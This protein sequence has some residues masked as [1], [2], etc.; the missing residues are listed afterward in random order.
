MAALREE[1]RSG[2]SLSAIIRDNPCL[3]L[4]FMQLQTAPIRAEP[5]LARARQGAD[6]DR[7]GRQPQIAKRRPCASSEI[8][9]EASVS[10]RHE[11]SAVEGR[12]IV[13]LSFHGSLGQFHLLPR[14]IL[15]GY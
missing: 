12:L 8:G 15:V 14:N 4:A 9:G 13:V 1:A 5:S 2:R 11:Y 3:P 10:L 6:P 7:Q